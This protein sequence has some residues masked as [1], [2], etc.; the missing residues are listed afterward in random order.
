[1]RYLLRPSRSL[2]RVCNFVTTCVRGPMGTNIARKA[3]VLFCLPMCSCVTAAH[4]PKLMWCSH[5]GLYS[6]P[7]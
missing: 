6:V 3:S 5:G 7:V 4:A 1:M 2:W